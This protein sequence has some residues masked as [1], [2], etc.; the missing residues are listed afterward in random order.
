MEN[1]QFSMVR[2]AV[3][4]D[5]LTAIFGVN[6][7]RMSYFFQDRDLAFTIKGARKKVFHIVKAHERHYKDG[8]VVPVRLHFRGEKEFDWAGYHV[9]ITVPGL[10][11]FLLSE[12]NIGVEDEYWHDPKEKYIYEGQFA[13]LLVD[14]M[15][16]GAGGHKR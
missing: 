10:D 9:K 5:D 16:A 12:V 11:H 4:K 13:K 14:K 6:I 2:V 8:R 15:N 3:H 7:R 1:Q